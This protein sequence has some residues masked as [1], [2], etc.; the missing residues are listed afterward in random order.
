MLK[1]NKLTDYATLIMSYLAVS[2]DKVASAAEIA[3]EL[4]LG[5]ATVSKL[6]KLLCHA[7]LVNSLRGAGG[8][9]QLAK[10]VADISLVEIISAVEGQLA[11]TECCIN[12]NLCSL[13]AA[14]SLKNNWKVINNIILMALKEF[15][16]KDMLQPLAPK[17]ITM[18]SVKQ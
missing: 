1:I 5:N 14:C 11:L 7:G 15:S 4:K 8:G 6:L 16:L 10:N 13:N 17:L 12:D 3:R 9:Y 18:Q 2:N